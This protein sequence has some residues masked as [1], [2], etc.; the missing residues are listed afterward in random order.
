MNLHFVIP[1]FISVLFI[2]CATVSF[3]LIRKKISYVLMS[4]FSDHWRNV[5][6]FPPV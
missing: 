5:I 4:K 6:V 3:V 2:H 1:S